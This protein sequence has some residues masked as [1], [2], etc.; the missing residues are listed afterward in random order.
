MAFD[1]QVCVVSENAWKLIHYS[2]FRDCTVLNPSRKSAI[3][4]SFQER[5]KSL[6]KGGKSE[7][8]ET[9]GVSME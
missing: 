1:L 7:Y 6:S 4:S 9:S 3:P 5:E 2:S 8:K